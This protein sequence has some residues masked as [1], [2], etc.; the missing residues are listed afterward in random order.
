MM[1]LSTK[2]HLVYFM[3]T[4]VMRL[5]NYDLKFIQNLHHFTLQ[6]KSVTTNQV[7]LFDKL[8]NKY[9][10]QFKKQNLTLDFLNNLPWTTKIV[11]SDPHFTDAFISV[12]DN[13]IHFRAPYNK[14]FITN[15][16]KLDYNPFVWKREVR[17]YE[18]PFSTMAL[19]ILVHL[20]HFYYPIIHYCPIIAELLNTTQKYDSAKYWHPTLVKIN[21]NFV[22]SATNEYLDKAVKHIQLND[23]FPTLVALAEYGISMEDNLIDDKDRLNFA[24]N[25]IYETELENI[26]T[27]FGYLKELGC[28]GVYFSGHSLLIKK[29]VKEKAKSITDNIHNLSDVTNKKIKSPDCKFPVLL[30]FSS[31]ISDARLQTLGIKKVIKIINSNPIDIK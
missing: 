9:E 2:E 15:F 21:G 1:Q 28:D 11:T 24:G 14:N 4:G 20:V 8:V 10:R 17:R 26:E 29:E 6:Q 31:M 25:Y 5:S 23:D 3:Q 30:Q 16:R 19:K 27:A 22:I 18:A 12:I 7:A 13:Q